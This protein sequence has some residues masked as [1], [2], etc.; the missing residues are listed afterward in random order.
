MFISAV[1]SI[2]IVYDQIYSI[3]CTTT[4]IATATVITD[5]VAVAI[6]TT[7]TA[8]NNYNPTSTIST[9]AS[10]PKFVFHNSIFRQ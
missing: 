6:F 1:T 10:Y 9:T 4:I 2:S 7:A 3:T 8:N 5:A